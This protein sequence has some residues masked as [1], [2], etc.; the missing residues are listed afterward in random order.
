MSSLE[1]DIEQHRTPAALVTPDMIQRLFVVPVASAAAKLGICV[2]LL[3]RIC[4]NFGILQWP[5]WKLKFVTKQ[6]EECTS[7][8]QKPHLQAE[9]LQKLPRLMY[10]RELLA[11][12]KGDEILL[13]VAPAR[14]DDVAEDSYIWQH[15]TATAPLGMIVARELAA[16]L[17]DAQALQ[18][19]L[20]QHVTEQQEDEQQSPQLQRE[21]TSAHQQEKENAIDIRYLFGR[22]LV[23]GREHID[24]YFNVV[25]ADRIKQ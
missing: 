25:V 10:A 3:K 13:D 6:I 24:P 2:A 19:R 20:S 14:Y 11:L 4:R 1:E 17:N 21:C 8:L 18:Q 15:T 23:F 22:F 16:Q 12:G 9:A 7:A 5:Y